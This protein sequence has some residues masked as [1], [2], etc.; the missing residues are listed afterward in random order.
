MHREMIMSNASIKIKVE[1]YSGYKANERP[2]SFTIRDKILKVKEI[3]DRWHGEDHD[4][5]KVKADDE[6]IYIIRYDRE[7][8]EW[9]LVMMEMG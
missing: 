4:Y 2:I 6:Y 8:D 5:F 3:I 9:E 1:A 7:R